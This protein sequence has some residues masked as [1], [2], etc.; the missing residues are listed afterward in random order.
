MKHRNLIQPHIL[1]KKKL[2]QISNTTIR[3]L[4]LPSSVHALPP[5]LPDP[6]LPTKS[7]RSVPN[8][9]IMLAAAGS[10]CYG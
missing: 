10:P 1:K 9:R 4:P 2:E 7:I 8:T 3:L 6:L 5:L